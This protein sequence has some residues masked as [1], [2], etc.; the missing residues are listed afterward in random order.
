MKRIRK[1]ISADNSCNHSFKISNKFGKGRKLGIVAAAA[2]LVMTSITVLA[3]TYQ[4]DTTNIFNYNNESINAL[5]NQFPAGE[6]LF[7]RGDEIT[8]GYSNV[9]SSSFCRISVYKQDEKSVNNINPS[10][11]FSKVSRI[12][13]GECKS[14]TGDMS[15][16]ATIPSGGNPYYLVT[17]V[18]NNGSRAGDENGRFTQIDLQFYVMP[19]EIKVSYFP[20]EKKESHRIMTIHDDITI[21]ECIFEKDGYECIGWSR[22]PGATTPEYVTGD[23]IKVTDSLIKSQFSATGAS[24]TAAGFGRI[25]ADNEAELTLYAVW[26]KSD[27]SGSGSGNGDSSTGRYETPQRLESA[28]QQLTVKGQNY[29]IISASQNTVAYAGPVNRK[30]ASYKV[31]YMISH[32]GVSYHVTEIAPGAFSG[33]KK[34]KKIT[35]STSIVK[36]GDS[37]FEGCSKLKSITLPSSV[38]EIGTR[39]FYNC[40]KLS[41]LTI[42]SG[43]LKKVGKNALGKTKKGIEIVTLT[44][45][46]AKYKKLFKKSGAKGAKY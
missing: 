36:I 16:T 11:N 35:I 14:G 13:Y 10:S 42:C 31:P 23:V 28:E 33:C 37:A 6:F 5:S 4:I 34:A 17:G 30:Q 1:V 3:T 40:K 21:K 18:R 38:K 39:A 15:A 20:D 43:K 26:K 9:G 2:M 22:T 8:V 45:Y 32:N 25:D 12:S 44:K 41:K 27:N 24:T 19:L 7:K 46:R 29:N